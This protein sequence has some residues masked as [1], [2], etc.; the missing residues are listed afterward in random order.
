RTVF[1]PHPVNECTHTFHGG[2]VPRNRYGTDLGGYRAHGRLVQVRQHEPCTASR[3]RTTQRCTNPVAS[4]GAHGHRV[5]Q[6]H[7][8]TPPASMLPP[9]STRVW[10]VI[11]DASADSRN[12]AALPMSAGTP[13][14]F[15]G[16]CSARSFSLPSNNAVANCVLTTAGAT[17]FT[18]T[19]GPISTASSSVRW[20]SAACVV[21]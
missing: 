12:A 1:P 20:V 17:A 5:C 7:V 8:H 13:S 19:S 6:L 18:R 16:Y 15:I 4:S 21:P 2:H 9:S 14:R 10:P 11:H 3:Q